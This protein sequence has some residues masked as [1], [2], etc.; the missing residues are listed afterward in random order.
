MRK[1]LMSATLMQDVMNV[2]K[3]FQT[4]A[5]LF[6]QASTIAPPVVIENIELDASNAARRRDT[7]KN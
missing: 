7:R 5:N 3:L 4:F 6:A 1:I 2:G